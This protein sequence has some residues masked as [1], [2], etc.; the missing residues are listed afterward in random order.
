LGVASNLLAPCADAGGV[1]VWA[2]AGGIID[3]PKTNIAITEKTLVL[4]TNAGHL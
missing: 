2:L 1:V 4:P 3:T